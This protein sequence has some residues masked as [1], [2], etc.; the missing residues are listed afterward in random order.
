[1]QVA[2]SNFLDRVRV[3][4]QPAHLLTQ[5]GVLPADPSQLAREGL[6]LTFRLEHSRQSAGADQR[7]EHERACEEGEREFQEAGAKGYSDSHL[8]FGRT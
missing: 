4:A 6:V 2:A 8:A 3:F 1:V 7:V 5:P